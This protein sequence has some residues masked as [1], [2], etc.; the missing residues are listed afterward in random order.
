[1]KAV[2]LIALTLGLAYAQS[3]TLVPFG[4]PGAAQTIAV[5]INNNG[6]I[7]GRYGEKLFVDSSSVTFYCFLRS[8]DGASYTA[9]GDPP[10]ATPGSTTCNGLNNLGQVA[11]TFADA[12]RVSRGYIRSA[13][14]DF[15]TFDL[16]GNLLP[17]GGP[18]ISD[19]NDRG[20]IVGV[21]SPPPY[22]GTGF[23]RNA[24]GE[25]VTLRAPVGEIVPTAVNNR[26]EIAGW[27]LNGSSQGTQHGFLRN[28]EGAYTKFDLPGTT[29]YTRISALNNAG[30]FAGNM[31]GGPGFVSNPDGS[32]SF[33]SGYQVNGLNDTGQIVASRL[34][35]QGYRGF[36]G[37][38]FRSTQPAIRTA[39]P[40]VLTSAEFGG[41]STVAPGIWIEIYGQN[42]AST[43]RHWRTSDFQGDTAP[44][45]LDGVGVRINGVPAFV[46]YVSPGQVNALVPSAIA[47]G[48][49]QVILT[50]G[51]QTSAPY[52]INMHALQPALLLT[53]TD[54]DPQTAYLVAAFP[55]FTRADRPK[56][57]DTIVLFGTGF[58]PVTPDVPVGRIATQPASLAASTQIT[59]DG[60]AGTATYAGLVPGAVGLYQFN[61]ALPD[62]FLN[63]DGAS[64]DSVRVVNVSAT[65]DGVPIAPGRFRRLILSMSK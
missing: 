46:S 44:T 53:P 20:E 7:L 19:I 16:P 10:G 58:G 54:Y 32:F 57:G 21:I 22:G 27:V 63:A 12:T 40:G 59:F 2:F 55:D 49:A 51:N 28:P 37:T 25:L 1:M 6:Q 45:S 13:A 39:L 15:T 47:P 34:E 30:Q 36:I 60:V 33:F 18:W 65:V 64:S 48:T 35:G 24:A 29:S 5:R 31:V 9:I 52:T 41:A 26:R 42:L 62:V 61:V 17:G 23:F 43:T 8:S 56:P 11:G 3:Y 50:N 14:G 4:Y 38:P